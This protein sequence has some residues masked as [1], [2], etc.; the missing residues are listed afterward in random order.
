M[1]F[2]HRLAGTWKRKV[3]TYIALT[4]F[5][6]RK[7]IEGGLPASRIVVKPNFLHP[8]PGARMRDSGYALFVGRLSHEKGISTLLKASQGQSARRPAQDCWET[9]HGAFSQGDCQ[10]LNQADFEALGWVTR[11][12]VIALLRGASF[13]VIPS[14][15][16]EAFP[17][18]IVEAL[19]CGVPVIGSRLGGVGEI[20]RHEESGLLFEPE[21]STGIG[22]CCATALGRHVATLTPGERRKVTVRNALH[23]RAKPRSDDG[24]LQQCYGSSAM[25][26]PKRVGTPDKVLHS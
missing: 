13:L 4:E 21:N 25:T 8:D 14:V 15:W 22:P 19:A 2:F 23:R 11:D 1:L 17:L 26:P 10:Q 7:Y 5:S 9:D 24:D 12:D 18:T 20:V 6:R 16:Y 3:D